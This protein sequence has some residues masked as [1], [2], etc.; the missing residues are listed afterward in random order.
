MINL[1]VRRLVSIV[2]DGMRTVDDYRDFVEKMLSFNDNLDSLF[3]QSR[4]LEI[5]KLLAGLKYE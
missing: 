4:E 5:K 1:T 2:G 3:G